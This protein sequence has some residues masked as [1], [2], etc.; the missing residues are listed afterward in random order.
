[1]ENVMDH[2]SIK[3]EAESW[4]KMALFLFN[5]WVGTKIP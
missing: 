4:R 3:I 1:M 5:L 2:V